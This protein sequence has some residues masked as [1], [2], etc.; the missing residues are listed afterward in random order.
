M[1]DPRL[2][3]LLDRYVENRLCE[4][5]RRELSDRL[6][7][8]PEACRLF[9]DYVHQ[10]A[11]L[12]ELM[13]EQV[14]RALAC[15]ET[16]P[17][18]R[19]TAARRVGPMLALALVLVVSL[20]LGLLFW[21][22][23]NRSG[24]ADSPVVLAELQ[25]EVRYSQGGELL[26]AEPGR[27]LAVGSE[28]ETGDGSIVVLRYGESS[29]LV[30]NA[31]SAI[32]LLD[33][34]GVFLLRGVLHA[35]VAASPGSKPLTVRTEQGEWIVADARFRS[36]TLDGETRIEMEE[37]SVRVPSGNGSYQELSKGNYALV[38]LP[39]PELYQSAPRLPI[40][41]EPTQM[42]EEASGPVQALAV[43]PDG[44]M[45][46]YP[47]SNGLVRLLKLQHPDQVRFLNVPE[48]RPQALAFSPDGQRL[49]VG[50]DATRRT[51][52]GA[53]NSFPLTIFDLNHQQILQ[54]FRPVRRASAVAYMPDGQTVAYISNEKTQR[55][56]NLWD[57][58]D[59][60]ERLR[61]VER[62]ERLT[63]LSVHHAGESLAA[64]SVAGF[65]YVADPHTGRTIHTLK[66]HPR[67]VQSVQ[68]S[69]D[70]ETIASGGRD[71]AIH[72]WSADTGERLRTLS[73]PFGEVRCLA[74]SPDG[75]M[76]ASGH[77]G[78]VALWD[79]ETGQIRTTL[80]A[81]RFAVS[82]LAYLPDGST[83]VTAGWDR[84][85]KFWPL[86]PIADH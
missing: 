7:S 34:T 27:R 11:M 48:G 58:G 66:A 60:R 28:L 61:L 84:C 31:D 74:F 45:L 78:S 71:G 52:T 69:P 21:R 82:A 35:E 55:G 41:K 23:E 1:M 17:S 2:L 10:H 54:S 83:L 51:P 67:D 6:R 40:S 49:L 22:S 37:G 12:S 53:K 18:Q 16:A 36:A 33:E 64:G 73:G 5:E 47:C 26:P 85:I 38:S 43:S 50:Y 25:G 24:L 70:G 39:E 86:E 81:H 80:N 76:L 44:R 29:R 46:A 15:T 65:L 59:A 20:G 77:G 75:R 32:R 72:L 8:S 56:I 3:D 42:V 9:W 68:Y 57:L 14:G 13:A 79:V 19:P 4:S 63:C 30:L 62:A